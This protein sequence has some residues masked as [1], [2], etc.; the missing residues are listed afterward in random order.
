MRQPLFDETAERFAKVIDESI[1]DNSYSR[2]RVFVDAVTTF[3]RPGGLILDYGCGPGRLSLLLARQ[4]FCIRGVDPSPS[5][6]SEAAKLSPGRD[7][8]S[9]AVISDPMEGFNGKAYDAIVCSSV[10]E[11]VESPVALLRYFFSVLKPAGVLILSFANAA[12]VW[13]RYAKLRFGHMEPHFKLQKHVWNEDLAQHNLCTA[14]FS[15]LRKAKYFESPVDK[16]P[17]LATLS[18]SRYVGTLGLLVA[19]KSE[20][21]GD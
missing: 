20:K 2:G 5:M 8:L 18:S 3:V 6:I 19:K 11:Y 9:F 1:R 17:L 15:L 4:G 13:R 7:D 16:R 21:A 14:G 10:I 12:S